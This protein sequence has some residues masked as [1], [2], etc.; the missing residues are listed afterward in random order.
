MRGDRVAQVAQVDSQ[1]L[2]GTRDW[3]AVD[4]PAHSSAL[5]KVF[6]AWEALPRPRPSRWRGSP[7]RRSPT[8]TR[9]A[10]TPG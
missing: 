1:F 7:T 3:T 2:L 6:Y 10:A 9:C 5:G 8:P 4:V